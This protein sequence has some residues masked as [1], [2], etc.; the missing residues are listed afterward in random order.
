MG[1]RRLRFFLLHPLKEKSIIEKRLEAV[2]ELVN[3]NEL[4]EKIRSRL[5][6]IFD[7]ERLISKI[8]SNTLTPRDMIALRESLKEIGELRDLGKEV[9]SELLR[10]IFKKIED[11]TW[12]IDKLDRT[13]EDNPP[14][15]LKEGGLIK[16]GVN[17]ELDELKEIKEKG[18]KWI[19][20]YQ[21]KLRQETGI[22]SLKIGFKCRAFYYR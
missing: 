12:L 9:K 11:Y 19:R 18:N 21:E 20:E 7:V 2:E 15:H 14:I 17:K 22:Q 4:R 3:N 16:K 13:L 1:K 8:T 6:N 5:D 10:R